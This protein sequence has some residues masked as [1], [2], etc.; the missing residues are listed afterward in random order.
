[1][2]TKR[3]QKISK[4]LMK[5]LSEIFQ[6]EIKSN[7]NVMISVTK[8][9]VTTDMSYARVYLSIFGPKMEDKKKVVEEVNGMSKG[10][11]KFLGDRV[12][13]QLRIIPELQ[14]FEDDSLDYIENIDHLL[15][16]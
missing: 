6:R 14:F 3:Q 10:I 2:E 9:N 13:H 7:G 5:E 11:R 4:L 15:K 1:M 12:R 8:V 16:D